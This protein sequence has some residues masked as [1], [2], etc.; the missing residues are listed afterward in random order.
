MNLEPDPIASKDQ[1]RIVPSIDTIPTSLRHDLSYLLLPPFSGNEEIPSTTA[2]SRVAHGTS[3]C[4]HSG[5]DPIHLLQSGGFPPNLSNPRWSSSTPKREHPSCTKTAPPTNRCTIPI[6][7]S[8]TRLVTPETLF[9]VEE[10]TTWLPDFSPLDLHER[11]DAISPTSPH[12]SMSNTTGRNTTRTTQSIAKLSESQHSKWFEHFKALCEYKL[13]HGDCNVSMAYLHSK[14]EVTLALWVKRV[15]HQYKLYQRGLHHSFTPERLELL[16]SIGFRWKVH[17]DSWS[18][19]FFELHTFARKHGHVRV[20]A[21]DE[22]TAGL[23]N[24]IKR[25]RKQHSLFL[26]GEVSTMSRDRYMKLR[27]IGLF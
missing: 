17:D 11:Q 16:R 25:Q 1:I 14:E 9:S 12:G 24:W 18:D 21:N 15:R 22:S 23:H 3:P 13:K 7:K 6:D 5:C 8:A 19:R 20:P 10:T 26:Q 27:D 2:S 4:I